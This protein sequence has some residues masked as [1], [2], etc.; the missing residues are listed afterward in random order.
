MQLLL[1][2][3]IL[4]KYINTFYQIQIMLGF[5][6]IYI[7]YLPWLNYITL[8]L[9]LIVQKIEH[10]YIYSEKYSLNL[11]HMNRN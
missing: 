1:D 9:N 10:S 5:E 4:L 8:N 2:T 11:S 3:A 6:I 7:K